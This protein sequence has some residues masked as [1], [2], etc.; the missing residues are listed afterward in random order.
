[1]AKILE[2]H[3]FGFDFRKSKDYEI[4]QNQDHNITL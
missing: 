2:V 4:D 1:M 3:K